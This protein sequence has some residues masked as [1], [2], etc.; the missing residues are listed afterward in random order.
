MGG[1]PRG[2]VIQVYGQGSGSKTTLTLPVIAEAQK[3]GSQAAFI[4][5]EHALDPSYAPKLGVDVDNLLGSQPDNGERAH[6]IAEALIRSNAVDII[7]VDLVAA[8]VPRAELRR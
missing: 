4:D 2:R 6:D 7:V 3:L 1:F 8:L 5:A